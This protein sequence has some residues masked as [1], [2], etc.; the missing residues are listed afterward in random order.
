MSTSGLFDLSPPPV[1]NGMPR[2]SRKTACVPSYVLPQHHHLYLQL[3]NEYLA[4]HPTAS[5][6]EVEGAARRGLEKVL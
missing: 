6:V 5:A 1:P 3:A 2:M 4:K